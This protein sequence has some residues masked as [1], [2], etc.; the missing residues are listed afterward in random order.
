MKPASHS[1]RLQPS[2]NHSVGVIAIQDI[3]AKIRKPQPPVSKLHRN[4]KAYSRKTKH[5]LQEE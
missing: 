4:K 2:E 3:D 5:P 1:V